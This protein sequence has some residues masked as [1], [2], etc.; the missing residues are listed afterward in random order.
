M[1]HYNMENSQYQELKNELKDVVVELKTIKTALVGNDYGGDEGL[2]RGHKKMFTDIYGTPEER[3]NSILTRMSSIEDKHKA[4]VEFVSGRI[5]WVTGVCVG[6]SAVL[7]FI[8]H[9]IK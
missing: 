1:K 8:F 4:H 2:I 7:G 5:L 9:F 3:A 6:G